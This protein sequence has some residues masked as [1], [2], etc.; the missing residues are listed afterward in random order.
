[1]WCGSIID[2]SYIFRLCLGIL[3]DYFWWNYFD[4]SK[5]VF[6]VDCMLNIYNLKTIVFSCN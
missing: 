6:I 2:E 4:I 5:C 3:K 1:M